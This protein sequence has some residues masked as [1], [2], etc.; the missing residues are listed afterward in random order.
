[1]GGR[2]RKEVDGKRKCTLCEQVK[3]VSDFRV[4]GYKKGKAYPRSYCRE[5]DKAQRRRWYR[6]RGGREWHQEYRR[7]TPIPARVIRKHRL[8][9][10]YG[11]TEADYEA[12]LAWQHGCCALC[13]D[14]PG[15]KRLAIDHD[16]VTGKVRSLLCR[17]C[18]TALGGFKDDPALIRQ[19]ANY[20]EQHRQD[21]QLQGL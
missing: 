12:L 20:I 1:M 9:K 14:P 3:D 19:A 10:H 21:S 6:E 16:H 8:K 18:N 2:K 17:G 15:K 5:C 11:M 4:G 7:R 13:G